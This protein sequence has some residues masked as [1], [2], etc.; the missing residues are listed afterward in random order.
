M[1]GDRETPTTLSTNETP[2][3]HTDVLVV[4]GGIAGSSLAF[5]LACRGVD[6]SLLTGA[7]P[8]RG[9]SNLPAAV[10]NAQRGRAAKATDLDAAGAAAT[11]ALA[12]RLGGLGLDPGVHR[13]GVVRVAGSARQAEAWRR[14]ADEGAGLE[15]FAA[16][17]LGESLHAPFGGVRVPGG[18]WVEPRR[19]LTAL[20]TAAQSERGTDR[21]A[22]GSA[23]PSA[24]H[25]T[26]RSA[27][28]HEGVDLIGYD[29]EHG[30]EHRQGN[31]RGGA[32]TCRTTA[33]T[34][35]ARRLVL[36]L[37]AYD[38]AASRLP[39]LQQE[40][41][42][43]LRVRLPEPNHDAL[44]PGVTALAGPVCVVAVAD[45]ELVITGGHVAPQAEI[46]FDGLLAAAAWSLPALSRAEI[47][48][49]WSALRAKRVSGTPV[50]RRLA[51]DVYLFGALGGRGFLTG[52]LLAARLAERL[53]R[54]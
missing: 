38:A 22:G 7:A 29:R 6:C 46:D 47:V 15:P 36:C 10:I 8:Q 16:G 9:A 53:S 52:P 26:V 43:A 3:D 2:P 39:H 14:L 35:T 4:G 13:G 18:G 49:R 32:L 48:A 11:L 12:A 25:G 27:V 23:D 28:V 17:D 19:L 1:S 5:E 54:S 40:R 51:P 30:A 45:D 34:V 44:P 24:D 31:G 33:G 42:G 20:R 41:G 50:V 37:G 21:S